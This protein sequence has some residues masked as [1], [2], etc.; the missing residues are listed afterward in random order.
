VVSHP[1]LT[2]PP[3]V[4]VIR[5]AGLE[6]LPSITADAAARRT[7]PA[8]DHAAVLAHLELWTSPGPNPPHTTAD[9]PVTPR[10]RG[11][12]GSTQSSQTVRGVSGRVQSRINVIDA[13]R[14]QSGKLSPA[15]AVQP[16]GRSRSS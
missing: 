14:T 6:Q 3:T 10:D 4:E 12:I 15:D 1:L 16:S 2:S 9:S 7:Q 13:A 5:Q 11:S 8:S